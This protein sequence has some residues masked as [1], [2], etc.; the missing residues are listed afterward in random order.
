MLKVWSL[1]LGLVGFSVAGLAQE[2]VPSIDLK[3]FIDQDP[4]SQFRMQRVDNPFAKIIAD[5]VTPFAA[6]QEDRSTFK[7]V[8]KG[9]LVTNPVT[10]QQFFVTDRSVH[11]AQSPGLKSGEQEPK[12]GTIQDF[13][14]KA[15]PQIIQPWQYQGHG[16]WASKATR[17]EYDAVLQ[18]RD[19]FQV[20]TEEQTRRKSDPL[21]LDLS[22]NK[23]R[24]SGPSTLTRFDV[25]VDRNRV[26]EY[27]GWV[28]ADDNGVVDD[29]LLVLDRNNDGIINNG[30]ELFGQN[31]STPNQANGFVILQ[32]L[33][34]N[35]DEA[36]DSKD[37]EWARLRVWVDANL[38]ARSE[39]VEL[40]TLDQL[41]ITTFDLKFNT[42]KMTI[43][44]H[45]NFFR[46]RSTFKRR[47]LSGVE[48][49][50]PIVNVWFKSHNP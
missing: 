41:G 7:N 46:E 18:G 4:N 16:V 42:D 49:S 44:S 50:L 48:V 38:N 20:V 11:R 37:A 6:V 29:G 2:A 15:N 24:L 25:D 36:I 12:E 26:A 31:E 1:S 21:I 32:V 5:D 35:K 39:P 40:F 22:G 30:T 23:I 33:D 14:D 19:P 17:E 8:A 13:P 10:R 27:T 9:N 28:A 3:G 45:G 47:A 43:D 34:S